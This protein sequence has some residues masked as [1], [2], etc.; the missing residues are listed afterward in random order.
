MNKR[1]NTF[2]SNTNSMNAKIEQNQKDF[3]EL[4]KKTV[5]IQLDTVSMRLK[6]EHQRKD[7]DD[8]KK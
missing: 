4:K 6:I 8:L 1:H 3:D 7:F 2:Q 5:E